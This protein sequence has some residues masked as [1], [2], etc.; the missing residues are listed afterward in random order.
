[1]AEFSAFFNACVGVVVVD[2]LEIFGLNLVPRDVWEAIKV[3]GHVADEVFH[4]HGVGV[5]GFGD[6]F[7]MT[8]HESR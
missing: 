5:G 2:A 4:E 1:M 6:V 7:F 8:H 3:G